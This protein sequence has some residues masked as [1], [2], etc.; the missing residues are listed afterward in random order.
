MCP[1]ARDHVVGIH[2]DNAVRLATHTDVG[3]ISRSVRKYPCVGGGHVS[4]RAEDHIDPAVVGVADSEL[5]A[6]RL[7]VYVE[8]RE[9]VL[10]L[11]LIEH[12]IDS[13]EGRVEHGVDMHVA[14]RGYY[15]HTVARRVE[16]GV[17]VTRHA[18]A[19]VDGSEYLASLVEIGIR[20]LVAQGVIS[21]R[22]AIRTAAYELVGELR[23][24]TRH[25]RC[26]LAVHN[27]EINTVLAPHAPQ[28]GR[29]MLNARRARHVANTKNFQNKIA[30]YA[31]PRR[32]FK[33]A[34]KT[35]TLIL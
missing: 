25:K 18:V 27:A 26:V 1:H 20:R 34:A 31:P 13:A 28:L 3:D 7:G 22:D 8:Y 14:H 35:F 12:L 2:T 4:M 17:A 32:I 23:R 24:D 19:E 29:K 9:V 21:A 30:F 6:R 5:L 11:A 10:T 16:D 33:K 15:E